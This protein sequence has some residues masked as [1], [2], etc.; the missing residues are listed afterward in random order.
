MRNSVEMRDVRV[1]IFG[2]VHRLRRQGNK[3]CNNSDI[4]I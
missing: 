4:D 2:W 3:T 1:K